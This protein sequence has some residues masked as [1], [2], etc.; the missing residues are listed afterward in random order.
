MREG[1]TAAR[2]PR[3]QEPAPARPSPR[4]TRSDA[5]ALLVLATALVAW[6]AVVIVRQRA[7]GSGVTVLRA[8]GSASAFRVDVNSAS[9]GELMLL[10]GI[11]E[12]RS[13]RI[14]AWREAQGRI[15]GMEELQKVAGL[16]DDQ[17]EQLRN[18]VSFGEAE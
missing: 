6:V 2:D 8:A 4:V 12:K 14:I 7:V 10:P 9:R 17:I 13:E 15:G 3:S 16:T 5:L 1:N 11:G 18:L